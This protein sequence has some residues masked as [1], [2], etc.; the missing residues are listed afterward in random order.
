MRIFITVC[1]AAVLCFSHDATAQSW[2]TYHGDYALTGVSTQNFPS[3]PSRLWRIKVGEGLPSAVVGGNGRLFCIADGIKITAMDMKGG[4]LWTRVI[5]LP[6]ST[7][8]E[9]PSKESFTAP[10]L[11]M[12]SKLLVVAADS[13]KVSGLSL[14]DGTTLWT[15]DAG[16]SIQGSPNFAA[17]KDAGGPDRVFVITNEDGI[18]HAINAEDGTKLWESEALERTDGH[19]AVSEQHILLGNCSAALIAVSVTNGDE[20][21]FVKVG[22]ECQMASGVAASKGQVFAGTRS[23]VLAAADYKEESLLWMNE[24][25]VGELFFTPAVTDK[26]VLIQDGD[27]VIYCVDRDSG[28]QK[29]SRE[30]EGII[31]LS[32]VIAGDLVIAGVDGMLSGFALKGG[33][34]RWSLEIGDEISP[35]AII[36]NMIIVGVDDGYVTAYGKEE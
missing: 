5:T 33:V 9:R 8:D 7:V 27:A 10:P 34:P 4:I 28:K 13:G 1:F 20:A 19:I 35:P 16:A 24:D 2:N 17:G 6:G 31:P 25:S 29:W 11:Y 22:P 36:D 18:L 3:K 21:A 12:N 15:Y 26:H 30:T 14:V 23:G 32:P